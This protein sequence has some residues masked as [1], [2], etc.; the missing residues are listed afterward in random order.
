MKPNN[1]PKDEF[2]NVL[3]EISKDKKFL[4]GFFKAILRPREYK[5]IAH[6]LQVFKMS[7]LG[8]PQ[9][10]IAKKLKVGLATVSRGAREVKKQDKIFK[11]IFQHAKKTSKNKG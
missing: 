4:D 5:E 7:F 11:K 9:R 3:V 1:K 6:R 10:Q 2:L 8:Y